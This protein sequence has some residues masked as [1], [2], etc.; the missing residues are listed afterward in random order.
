VRDLINTVRSYTKEVVAAFCRRGMSP[1][2]VQLGNEITN[3]MLW[4][5]D[6]QDE[7][8]GGRL[9][10]PRT[11][12]S[13]LVD[14]QWTILSE[15]LKAAGVGAREG[16][17]LD[18]GGQIL[19]H[20]DRGADVAGAKW[21]LDRASALG[22]DY[23]LVGLSFYSL[24]HD[25]ATIETLSRLREL[26]DSGF[27]RPVMISETSYPFRPFRDGAVVRTAGREFTFTPS[28]QFE[29]LQAA[30]RTMRSAPNGAGLFWWGA[31]FT[32]S[33]IEACRDCFQAQA[34]FDADGHAL[35]ALAAFGTV[36]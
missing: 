1:A 24:W 11:G 6:G 8:G 12:A 18:E 32:D 17:R 27:R 2:I 30:L 7:R 16:F 19:L 14:D 10:G 3:G 23:D 9:H 26:Y 20:L 34:L 35:P 5:E 36:V 31:C 21:W 28:G 4:V 29:Y 25:N 33:S 22:V 13:W 15:F